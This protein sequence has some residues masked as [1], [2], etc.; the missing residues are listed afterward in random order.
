[1]KNLPQ[2]SSVLQHEDSPFKSQMKI[3]LEHLSKGP[4]SRR[5]LSE[6]TNIPVSNICRF[7]ANWKVT[8]RIKFAFMGKCK[9]SRRKVEYWKICES[10]VSGQT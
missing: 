6:R 9:I 1:M 2:T 7:I 8:G 10:S 3:A 4:H 5:M